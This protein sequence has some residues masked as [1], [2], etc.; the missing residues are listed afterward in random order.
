MFNPET[1]QVVVAHISDKRKDYL[2]WN[3]K[4]NFVADVY[5]AKILELGHAARYCTREID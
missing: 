2:P 5:E 4:P 3:M 1:D